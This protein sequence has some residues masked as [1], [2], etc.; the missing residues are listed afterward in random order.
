[1]KFSKIIGEVD[2]K[3]K[4]QLV[5]NC[6]NRL[7]EIFSELSIG[8]DQKLLG[9]QMGGDPL[10]MQLVA[11]MTHYCDLSGF[12]YLPIKLAYK[13]IAK[14]LELNLPLSE[15]DEEVV[16]KRNEYKKKYPQIIDTAGTNGKV[17]YWAPQFVL[18]RSKIG[19]RLLVGHEGMHAGLFHPK[20]RGT[21]IPSLWNIA[22][23]FK[24]NYNLLEDLRIRGFRR[25]EETFKELAD[26]VNL[27]DY[28]AFV[29]DPYNPPEKMK[30]FS[31]RTSLERILE[32][33][34]LTTDY[35]DPIVLYA[36][37]NL[38]K[39]LRQPEAIYDYLLKQAPVCKKCGNM[40]CYKLPED[41]Q[42]MKRKLEKI[43]E[44][45]AKEHRNTKKM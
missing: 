24:S 19:I 39:E 38:R 4:E 33:N 10:L 45:N 5:E 7:S 29:R 11:P 28:A 20:R 22:I 6:Q 3:E 26:F 2:T 37:P 17:F 9:S 21:R 30:P 16:I 42:E 32:P 15:E 25:P 35:N 41:V 43:Q 14:K 23:D 31:P 8:W 12:N 27:E 44:Q 18:S 36:E 13:K 1:M 34:Y 40:Y